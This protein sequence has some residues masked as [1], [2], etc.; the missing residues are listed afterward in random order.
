[1]IRRK[2]SQVSILVIAFAGSVFAQHTRQ[3][4]FYGGNGETPKSGLITDGQGNYYGS[5]YV[6]G[7][8]GYG[9]IYR[10][11]STANFSILYSFNPNINDGFRPVGNLALDQAGNIYGATEQGGNNGDG[12]VFELS[13]PQQPGGSWTETTLYAFP[14]GPNDGFLPEGGLIFDSAGN[15]Y[16]T[17]SEGGTGGSSL[18]TVYELSPPSQPDG[19]WTETILWSFG[20]NI[21]NSDAQKPACTLVMDK[22]GNLYGTA[23][24]G[25]LYQFG[26]VFEVSPPSQPGGAWTE[27]LPHSFTN[28]GDGANPVAGLTL[29]Q[30]NSVALFGVT[31][32]VKGVSPV[33]V[34]LPQPGGSWIFEV[35]TSN[36]SHIITA[37]LVWGGPVTLYGGAIDNGTIFSISLANHNPVVTQLYS[38]PTF[39][40]EGQLLLGNRAIYGTSTKGGPGLCNSDTGCGTVWELTP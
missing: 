21:G 24:N 18:G 11:T 13:P 10:I 22:Q 6:G 39:S 4:N 32:L 23:P 5:T 33:F 14:G 28:S 31:S 20:G 1:M 8:Y 37:P 12:T 38:F 29:G 34:L 7:A 35:V 40:I 16:G 26:A 27:T 9:E 15:L 36:L 2:F 19:N 3:F 17:T 25:G 30:V